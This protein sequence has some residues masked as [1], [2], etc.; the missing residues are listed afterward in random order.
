MKNEI[1]LWALSRLFILSFGAAGGFVAAPGAPE[2]AGG[3]A[4]IVR[5]RAIHIVARTDAGLAGRAV[6]RGVTTTCD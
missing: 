5:R 2:D 3:N 1:S 4:S 6:R